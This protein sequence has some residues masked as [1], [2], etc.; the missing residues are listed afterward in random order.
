MVVQSDGLNEAIHDV[1][2]VP[3]ATRCTIAV[4]PGAAVVISTAGSCGRCDVRI[5]HA[6]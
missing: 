6:A 5:L 2:D 4:E 3:G 1:A